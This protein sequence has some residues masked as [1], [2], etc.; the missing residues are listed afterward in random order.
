M[1]IASEE[2]DNRVYLTFAEDLHDRYPS[3]SKVFEEM[4]LVEASH[5]Q[6]LTD[7]YQQRFGSH[8][9]PIRR[10]DV[11][12]FIKRPP[13][14]LTKNLSLDTIRREAELREAEAFG[15]YQKAAKHAQ[16]PGVRKL[17]SDLAETEQT[18]EEIAANLEST[19]SD[20]WRAGQGSENQRP[21]FS[22]AICAAGARRADGWLG[23]Y[24]GASVRGG[25]RDA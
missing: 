8:I 25:F 10:G 22:F 19:N 7:L 6:M 21:D 14:W 17:L 24:S 20:A 16:D 3:T 5:H 15:F 2:D 4:A 11:N 1:A 13:V 9:L 23:V 12:F 18:H